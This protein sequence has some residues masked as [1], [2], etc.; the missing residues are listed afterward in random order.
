MKRMIA[1]VSITMMIGLGTQAFA[2]CCDY[3]VFGLEEFVQDS[4]YID[5]GGKFA[6]ETLQGKVLADLPEDAF[7]PFDDVIC[8][9]DI[10][11]V[12][13]YHPKRRDLMES[14]QRINEQMGGFQV[15]NGQVSLPDIPPVS[16][17]GKTLSEARQELRVQLKERMQDAD[18]YLSFKEKLQNTI[19]LT[20]FVTQSNIP[21]DG[22]I[23]L[24]EVLAKAALPPE[25]NLFAS[26]VMRNGCPLK[27][28][29]QRLLKEGDMSQNIIMRGGDKI[30]I[31]SPTDQVAMVMGEVGRQGLIPIIRGSMSLRE[32]LAIARGI[33]FTGDK[34]H[35][36]VIRGG[37]QRTK[38]Y[39]FS[40]K[41]MLYEPNNHLLL[42]P[43]D[44]VFISLAP[45][46][47]WFLF[48]QQFEPV[49]RGL[50][51][52]QVIHAMSK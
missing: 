8:E 42:I 34:K 32:A 15:M 19:E 6:I 12:A 24:Y 44:L 4:Q 18:V 14:V 25:A 51:T 21:V 35:M 2:A 26:Y 28:D 27:L 29:L 49:L 43:G 11:R 41:S 38:I 46:T 37:L 16:I 17:V 39:T 20:G 5:E 36:Q 50:V 47:E 7:T 22:K 52:V 9:G 45:I 3:R 10:L 48:V 33:P 30:F 31:G 23:R 1:I 13:F 40:W